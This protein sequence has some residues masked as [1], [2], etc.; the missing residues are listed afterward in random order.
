MKEQW[1]VV[2]IKDTD[3]PELFPFADRW[4]AEQ[5]YEMA[6]IQWSGVYLCEIVKPHANHGQ[7]A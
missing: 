7:K 1:L 2:R 3:P 5:F 6:S 4:D